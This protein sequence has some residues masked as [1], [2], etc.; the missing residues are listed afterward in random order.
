[1]EQKSTIKMQL[2]TQDEIEQTL[3]VRCMGKPMAQEAF[4]NLDELSDEAME[5]AVVALDNLMKELANDTSMKYKDEYVIEEI[6]KKM[7]SSG[8]SSELEEE[9]DAW[10]ERNSVNGA[11][12]LA[13]ARSLCASKDWRGW[14]DWKDELTEEER[15]A[16]RLLAAQKMAEESPLVAEMWETIYG[17]AIDHHHT[18]TA[19][20]ILLSTLDY[21]SDQNVGH[22]MSTFGGPSASWKVFSDEEVVKYATLKAHDW[23]GEIA[24]YNEDHEDDEG[25]DSITIIERWLKETLGDRFDELRLSREDME[26]A[27]IIALREEMG[28]LSTDSG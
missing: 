18:L 4:V 28:S 8:A 24:E 17:S 2:F 11:Y 20:F 7:A 14:K 15:D 13:S 10:M 16:A 5:I 3:L 25:I 21:M 19:G 23:I 6:K 27:D 22:I 9:L 1:M 26:R 12:R